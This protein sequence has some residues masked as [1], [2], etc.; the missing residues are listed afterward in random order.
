MSIKFFPNSSMGNGNHIIDGNFD[1][2]FEG[3]VQTTS[4]YGSDTMSRN[5]H[6][7]CTKT[8]SRGV[9]AAG[10]TDSWDAPAT[11]YSRTV[12]TSVTGA[13]NY[14]RKTWRLEDV[15][16]FV[17]KSQLSFRG[18][19]PSGAAN[20]AVEARQCFGAGGSSDVT[21]IGSQ[22]VPLATEWAKKTVSLTI[23]SIAG[24]TIGSGSY[25]EIVIWFDAGS[26]FSTRAANLGQRSGTFDIA[27][28]KFEI[29]DIATRF[30]WPDPQHELFRLQRHY[31]STFPNF[32]APAHGTGSFTYKSTS[33][34]G[35][36]PNAYF[37]HRFSIV[38]RASP[39][40]Y[41]YD[42]LD[43]QISPTIVSYFAGVKIIASPSIAIYV[44]PYGLSGN[45]AHPD[46]TGDGA[47]VLLCYTADARL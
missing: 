28:V 37:D 15:S 38:M 22:L 17:G 5:E 36:V 33:N 24:K 47:I 14:V 42:P 10:E 20:V 29:G 23:P 26:G 44:N 27:Q 4:G 2:W 41:Y 32:T 7:G 11:C 30:V 19:I 43:A 16:R 12:V 35:F 34:G 25:L 9:F 21:G 18:R 46:I 39:S 6:V 8:H 1:F 3:T 45:I 40:M 13:A 31:Q